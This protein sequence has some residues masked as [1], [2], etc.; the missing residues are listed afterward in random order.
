[1]QSLEEE[2]ADSQQQIE[3]FHKEMKKIRRGKR[4]W[5][6]CHFDLSIL[7]ETNLFETRRHTSSFHNRIK[8][9]L[10]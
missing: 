2:L 7:E 3:D 5:L 9:H 6:N 10:E 8:P 1:M 4:T